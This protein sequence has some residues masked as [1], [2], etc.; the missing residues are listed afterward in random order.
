MT[1]QSD[2]PEAYREQQEGMKERIETALRRFEAL[3]GR[4]GL[5]V[6]EWP[7]LDHPTSVVEH[8]SDEVFFAASTNK[9][10]VAFALGHDRQGGPLPYHEIT[11]RLAGAGRFDMHDEDEAY[12]PVEASEEELIDDMLSL[13]GNTAAKVL[14]EAAG[15]AQRI[16]ELLNRFG[17]HEVQL[18]VRPNGSSHLG[19]A[20][21]RGL[22]TLLRALSRADSTSHP[23]VAEATLYALGHNLRSTGIRS[24]MSDHVQQQLE[25]Q[26]IRVLNKSGEYPRDDETGDPV[27]H[28]IGLV[29][30]PDGRTVAYAVMAQAKSGVLA[31]YLRHQVTAEVLEYASGIK[32]ASLPR[33]LARSAFHKL[34]LPRRGERPLHLL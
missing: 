32:A 1:E 19:Y 17:H 9:L 21:P 10:A 11:E 2:T 20:T 12:E 24:V 22:M 29:L 23:D 7:L 15:G 16:N 31:E 18:Y 13:S 25:A 34:G 27:R 5:A 14:K 26:D 8:G 28:D 6:C 30:L 33:K 3:G 4:A